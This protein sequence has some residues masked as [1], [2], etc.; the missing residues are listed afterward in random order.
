M[1]DHEVDRHQRT[2]D[3]PEENDTIDNLN[4]KLPGVLMSRARSDLRHHDRLLILAGQDTDLGD[5]IGSVGE[6]DF[7]GGVEFVGFDGEEES[8]RSLGIGQEDLCFF[9]NVAGEGGEFLCEFEVLAAATGDV[10]FLD[11]FHDRGID[12]RNSRRINA[13]SHAGFAAKVAEVSEK[14]K[15]GHVGTGAR[16]AHGGEGGTRGVEFGHLLGDFCFQFFRGEAF[17][18]RGGN[19]PGA[20]WFGEEEVIAGLAAGV[21]DGAVRVDQAGHGKSVERLGIEH[22]VATG[23]GAFSFGDL[24][25]SPEEDLVDDVE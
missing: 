16:H 1:I 23:E 15:A 6:E 24:V 11:E 14:P 2:T 5:D 3:R 17:A 7:L 12:G 10:P 8:A 18:D 4:H 22:G 9:R 19:D 20:E 21:G 13:S 25:G